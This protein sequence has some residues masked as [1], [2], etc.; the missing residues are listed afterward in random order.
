[1]WGEGGGG[2]L[3]ENKVCDDCSVVDLWIEKPKNE[4]RKTEKIS[5]IRLRTCVCVM[6]DTSVVKPTVSK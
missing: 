5:T 4:A 1:M 2:A 6:V 3:Q